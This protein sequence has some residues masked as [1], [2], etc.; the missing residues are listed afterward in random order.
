LV[1]L[2]TN[3]NTK[4]KAHSGLSDYLVSSGNICSVLCPNTYYFV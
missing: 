4:K 3:V 1:S 2:L